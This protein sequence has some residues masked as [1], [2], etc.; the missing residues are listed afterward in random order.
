[1]K[2]YWQVAII[3]GSL[4]VGGIGTYCILAAIIAASM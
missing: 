3:I 1:M 2:W 4:I